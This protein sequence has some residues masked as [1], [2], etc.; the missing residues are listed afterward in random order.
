MYNSKG[1]KMKHFLNKRFTLSQLATECG[2]ATSIVDQWKSFY[3]TF[4][5]LDPASFSNG[6]MNYGWI[7]KMICDMSNDLFIT[8]GQG[9]GRPDFYFNNKWCETKSF[10]KGSD[11]PFPVASSSFFGSNCKVPKHKELLAQSKQQAK[12]FLF[13]HSYDKNDYYLLTST[14]KLSCSFC[15]IE[16]IFIT[17]SLLVNCLVTKSEYKKVCMKEINKRIS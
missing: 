13:E 7:Q 12:V 15:E 5:Q 11:R 10:I 16:L 1:G 14:G 3:N 17:K 4:Q 6:R 2:T 9:N 8:G